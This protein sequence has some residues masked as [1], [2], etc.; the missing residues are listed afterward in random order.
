MDRKRL[1]ENIDVVINMKDAPRKLKNAAKI[2][3]K[4][5]EREKKILNIT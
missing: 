1:E 2:A 3:K 5:I 4:L